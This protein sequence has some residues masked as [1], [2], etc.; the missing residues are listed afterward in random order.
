MQ[1][2]GSMLLDVILGIVLILILYNLASS[3]AS[4]YLNEGKISRA[5]TTTVNYA[6]AISQYRYEIGE[7]P[8]TLSDLTKKGEKT[9]DGEDATHFGPWLP[10]IDKDPWDRDYVYEVFSQN[11]NEDDTFVVYS[12]GKDGKGRYNKT[13][14][15]FTNDAIGAVGK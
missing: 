9:V 8:K 13:K 10:K 12:K 6:S 3:N 11:G 1:R 4:E 5:T 2:K 7:Y 14:T 15:I